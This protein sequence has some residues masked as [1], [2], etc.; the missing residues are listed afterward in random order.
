MYHAVD[1][2]IPQSK[3]VWNSKHFWVPA[4]WERRDSR[5]V[6]ERAVSGTQA[7]RVGIF[8]RMKNLLVLSGR[9]ETLQNGSFLGCQTT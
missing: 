7:A 1:T 9:G 2:N 6:V 4:F 5:L 8:I 3:V